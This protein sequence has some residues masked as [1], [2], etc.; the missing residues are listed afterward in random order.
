MLGVLVALLLYFLYDSG[1]FSSKGGPTSP[2]KLAV[3]KVLA[4]S[5]GEVTEDVVLDIALVGGI[6]W[7]GKWKDDPFYYI[8]PETL[9]AGPKK[10]LVD[11][12]LG[13]AEM[14]KATNMNL[15]GISWHGNSGYAIINGNIAK[16]GDKISGYT[17]EKIALTYVVLGKG[18]QTIRLSLE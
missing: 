18:R 5:G 16:V 8:A 15:T 1:M 9:K 17:V 7:D 14:G 11:K 4:E 12:L 10:G 13:S 2:K 6:E 3:E